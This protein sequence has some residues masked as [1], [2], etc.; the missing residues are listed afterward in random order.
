VKL[1]PRLCILDRYLSREWTK[2]FVVTVLGFPLVAIILELTDKL[3]E[4]LARGL[5]PKAIALSYVFSIPEKVFLIVPAAVLFATVFSVVSMSRHAELTAQKASG[6]SFHRAMVPV[7]V[8]SVLA[9][10]LGLG[11]GE[12]APLLKRRQLELLGEREIR[13][14]PARYNFVYRADRGWVYAIRALDAEQRVMRDAVLERAGAGPDYPTIIVHAEA[15]EYSESLGRWVLKEGRMRMVMGA[16]EELSFGFDSLR[17]SSLVEPPAALLAE[18]K[19]PEEMRYGELARYIGWLERSGGDVRKLKVELAL[20]LAIPVTSIII[21]VFAAPLAITAP[22]ASGAFGVGVSLA[23]TVI[24]LTL[25]QLSKAVGAGG[26]LP[27]T[28][29]A[30]MPNILFGVA[31]VWLFRRAPT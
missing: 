18:P 4:Y 19:E 1:V 27:P 15:G 11:L 13:S 17:L 28:L 26:V 25:V 2:I 16:Q 8:A 9:A 14:L 23:I 20:K 10:L 7:L 6:R 22:R 12:L 29:A 21:A 24:F 5:K 3:D 30:W 31:G